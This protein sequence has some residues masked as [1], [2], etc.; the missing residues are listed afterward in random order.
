MANLYLDHVLIGVR[1]LDAA[2]RSLGE[3]LGFSLTPEG[4][5]PGRGTGNRLIPF[6]PDY[7]E[8]IAVLDPA[9]VSNDPSPLAD[10]LRRREG[11]FMFA[12]GT[13]DINDTVAH[14]R[15]RGADVAD[16]ADGSISSP[17]H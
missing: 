10:F 14:L 15:S 3:V 16:R 17:A 6:G 5:H 7:L 1:L 9:D 2:S 12:L 11:L 13:D 4:R 8:L